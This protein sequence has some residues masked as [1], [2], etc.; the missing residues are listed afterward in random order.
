[1]EA[2]GKNHSVVNAGAEPFRISGSQHGTSG[3]PRKR[4]QIGG[5]RWGKS[6]MG[7]G[8]MAMHC[9]GF[10]RPEQRVIA[11]PE[12]SGRRMSHVPRP[13]AHKT[14]AEWLLPG[15]QRVCTFQRRTGIGSQPASRDPLSGPRKT[16]GLVTDR[17]H[18]YQHSTPVPRPTLPLHQQ[19]QQHASTL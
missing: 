12:R 8:R 11:E 5:G 14:H 1:M 10:M 3:Q 13:V 2:R 16:A 15:G 7:C 9:S 18:G 4:R 17:W 6:K 19:E